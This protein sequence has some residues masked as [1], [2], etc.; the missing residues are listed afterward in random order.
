MKK[1][2]RYRYLGRNGIITTSVL[3]ENVEP[4]YMYR[5]IAEEGMVLT[6]GERYAHQVEIFAEDLNK[7]TEIENPFPRDQAN[8]K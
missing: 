6:N 1:I 5:L 2:N 7:W 8:I 3:L 4:I